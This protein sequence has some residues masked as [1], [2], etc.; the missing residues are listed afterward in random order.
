[1]KNS[2]IAELSLEESGMIPK[3][4]NTGR[5]VGFSSDVSQKTE[6]KH[7]LEKHKELYSLS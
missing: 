3:K 7:Q 4:K 2:T 5:E 1:M 6:N